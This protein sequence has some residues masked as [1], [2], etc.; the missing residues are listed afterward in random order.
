MARP[1]R[2]TRTDQFAEY[3]AEGLSITD[4][5]ERMGMSRAH[6]DQTAYRIRKSLG[7]Q[8]R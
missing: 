3:L 6:A 4:I 8:A 1:N 7:E 2:F 5:A